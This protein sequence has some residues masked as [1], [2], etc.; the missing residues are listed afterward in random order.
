MKKNL[1]LIVLLTLLIQS[2]LIITINHCILSA[3]DL[4]ILKQLLPWVNFIV[5]IILALTMLSIK[6]LEE[7]VENRTKIKLLRK[8][9]LEMESLNLLLRSQ[10]HEYARHVQYIQSLAYIRRYDE[11]MDYINAL[12]KEYRHTENLINTGHPAITTLINT[13]R[14]TAESQGIEF[15]VAVKSDLS[16]LTVPPWDLNSILGNLIENAMEAA[17]EASHPRVAIEFSH[18]NCQYVFY[19][20]NNGATIL[21]KNRIYELGYSTKGSSSRGYGLFVVKKLVDQYSGDIEISCGKKTHFTVKLPDG[22][23]VDDKFYL[24]EDSRSLG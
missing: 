19:I 1:G 2:L 17:L 16:K 18:Q 22:G 12:A 7:D 13:K 4:N 20:A 23:L 9:V 3:Q 8:H 21:D 24:P 5:L 11:L 10:K 6:Q 14:N 15:V